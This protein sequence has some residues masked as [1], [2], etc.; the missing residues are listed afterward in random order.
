MASAD[1]EGTEH[2]RRAS[3]LIIRVVKLANE[4]YALV[5]L[6]FV[7]PLLPAGERLKLR[8]RGR[9]FLT[10]QPDD[11]IWQELMKHLEQYLGSLSEVTGW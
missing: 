2:D 3:P 11:A 10:A 5:L 7:T 8:H 4:K 1:L 9:E 6:R